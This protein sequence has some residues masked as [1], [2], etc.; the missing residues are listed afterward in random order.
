MPF[1]IYEADNFFVRLF[2]LGIVITWN[3]KQFWSVRVFIFLKNNGNVKVHSLQLGIRDSVFG[4]R[5]SRFVI[6][7]LSFGNRKI[8]FLPERVKVFISNKIWMKAR[9]LMNNA[10]WNKKLKRAWFF[11]VEGNTLKIDFIQGSKFLYSK[12]SFKLVSKVIWLL[13]KKF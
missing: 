6:R 13:S 10:E 12:M 2:I 7:D 1:V 9:L 8:S 11:R 5:Y 4:I 3:L